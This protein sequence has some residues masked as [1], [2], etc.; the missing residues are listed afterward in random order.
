MRPN[1]IGNIYL[2]A[3]G[4]YKFSNNQ[5]SVK[6]LEKSTLERLAVQYI[7]NLGTAANLPI[8]IMDKQ[9]M[10]AIK[11]FNFYF[12][13]IDIFIGLKNG[14]QLLY[15]EIDIWYPIPLLIVSMK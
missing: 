14:H 13:Y 6:T 12:I 15:I 5:F 11:F 8:S 1:N 4:E 9:T 3:V 10:V 2:S 7:H